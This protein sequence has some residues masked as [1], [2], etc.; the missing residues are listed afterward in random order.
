MVHAQV[1]L[2]SEASYDIPQGDEE[3]GWGIM[4][5]MIATLL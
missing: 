3:G 4:L 2:S 5:G 1:E